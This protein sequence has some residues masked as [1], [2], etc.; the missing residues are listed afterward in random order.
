MLNGSLCLRACIVRIAEQQE[1]SWDQDIGVTGNANGFV[2]SHGHV[3]PKALLLEGC[4][5]M[6]QMDL[7][8]LLHSTVSNYHRSGKFLTA[9]EHIS[10]VC[11]WE[12]ESWDHPRWRAVGTL[13]FSSHCGVL[14]IEYAAVCYDLLYLDTGAALCV[15]FCRTFSLTQRWLC[16][17]ELCIKPLQVR[18]L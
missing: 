16:T 8:I 14:C 2:C 3:M 7:Q 11:S 13:Q 6:K 5:S 10:V 18:T 12:M 1:E 17:T 15:C 9:V 4:I